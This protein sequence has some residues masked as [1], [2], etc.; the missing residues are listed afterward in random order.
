MLYSQENTKAEEV[1][2]Y[3]KYFTPDSNWSWYITEYDPE[4]RIFF[5]YVK[6]L[7]KE[8]GDTSLTELEQTRGPL[9]IKI[10]RDTSFQPKNLKI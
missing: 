10:K 7:E 2:V 3:I 9:G 1:T 8:W 5:G 6:G 4:N